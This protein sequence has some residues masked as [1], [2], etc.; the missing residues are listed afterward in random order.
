MHGDRN[1][2]NTMGSN[3]YSYRR[4]GI[5]T[6]AN[7]AGYALG[8]ERYRDLLREAEEYRLAL[9]SQPSTRPVSSRLTLQMVGRFFARLVSGRFPYAHTP[10]QHTKKSL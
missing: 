2:R 8:Q 9:R 6:L 10:L 5:P 7:E 4:A 3:T 1:M